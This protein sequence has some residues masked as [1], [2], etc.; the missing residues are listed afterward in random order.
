MYDNDTAGVFAKNKLE[1]DLK[2]IIPSNFRIMNYP[3]IERAKKYP[4]I[5]T[6]NKIINDNI[7]GRACSI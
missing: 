2:N 4:T 5:G 6:N 3:N 7:N 1:Y